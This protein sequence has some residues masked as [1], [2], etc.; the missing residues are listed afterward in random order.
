MTSH[1]REVAKLEN[2]WAKRLR[3]DDLDELVMEGVP[4]LQQSIRSFKECSLPTSLRRENLLTEAISSL[5]FQD[6]SQGWRGWKFARF[7]ELP[8]RSS[9]I[10]VEYIEVD[11][12]LG[13]T[14]HLAETGEGCLRTLIGFGP[15]AERGDD[16][17]ELGR[18]DV[19][20]ES[21]GGA[22]DLHGARG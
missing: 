9:N 11:V 13:P 15:G 22:G 7:G 16:L 12:V 5:F 3:K 2:A 20:S 1:Y 6:L 18:L 4:S 17:T 21:V 10:E 19:A 14:V 8:F